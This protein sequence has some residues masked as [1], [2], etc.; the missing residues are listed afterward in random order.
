MPQIVA[1]SCTSCRR[2]IYDKNVFCVDR[3]CFGFALVGRQ[4]DRV[5]HRELRERGME[6][7]RERATGGIR[8]RIVLPVFFCLGQVGSMFY[9]VRWKNS[10]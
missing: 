1:Q 5:P 2:L 9:R 3:V 10:K 6:G 8:M 7:G 4:G